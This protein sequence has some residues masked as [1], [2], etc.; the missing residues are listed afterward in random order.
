MT[1]WSLDAEDNPD[2]HQNLI[3]TFSPIY[4]VPRNLHANLFR[5]ICIKTAKQKYAIT[6]NLLC[7]GN[8]VFIKY[9]AQGFF[10]PPF[11]HP[12]TWYQHYSVQVFNGVGD[13]AQSTWVGYMGVQRSDGARVKTWLYDSIPNSAIEECGKYRRS[14]TTCPDLCHVQKNYATETSPQVRIKKRKKLYESRTTLS[15]NSKELERCK[16][17][18]QRQ[19]FAWHFWR[20]NKVKYVSKRIVG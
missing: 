12:V 14:K 5:G 11:F 1:R 2:S 13:S 6:I 15:N 9:Q 7:A 17:Y 16:T 10:S 4:N 20:E 19:K 3:I 8:N 18:V